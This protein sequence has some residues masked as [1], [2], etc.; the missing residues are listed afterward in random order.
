MHRHT[1]LSDHEMLMRGIQN[2]QS[3]LN[4]ILYFLI[5]MD[6]N[7]TQALAELEAEVASQTTVVDSLGTF[8]QGLAD[9][10]AAAKGDVTKINAILTSV[11][12]NSP[13]L[14]AALLIGTP[15]EVPQ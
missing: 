5:Q 4:T 13:K 7:F 2:L 14:A 1:N 8:I 9:Q 11:K 10:I 15:N 12:A 6:N 3:T